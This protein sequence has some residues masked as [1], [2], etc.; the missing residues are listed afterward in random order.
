MLHLFHTLGWLEADPSGVEAH[1]LPNDGEPPVRA[2]VPAGQLHRDQPR[3]V[4]GTLPNTEKRVHAERRHLGRAEHLDGAA[5][6]LQLPCDVGH[7]LGKQVVRCSVG[8]RAPEFDA[9]CEQRCAIDGLL[10]RSAQ[11]DQ[12]LDGSFHRLGVADPPVDARWPV[13]PLLGSHDR[14]REGVLV[15][16][17]AKPEG[18]SRRAA[19]LQAA[20]GGGRDAARSPGA[21]TT[22]D[23]IDEQHLLRRQRSGVD[24]RGVVLED[25]ELAPVDRAADDARASQKDGKRSREAGQVCRI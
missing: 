18:E 8:Q 4:R 11:Q 25:V 6:R 10:A 1:A 17:V 9:F 14:R 16:S 12:L 7:A 21:A 15:L 23:A 19:T 2:L 3:L 22:P 20:R 5:V 13:G 24:Q